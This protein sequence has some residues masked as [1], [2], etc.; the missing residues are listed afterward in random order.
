MCIYSYFSEE[1]FSSGYNYSEVQQKMQFKLAVAPIIDSDQ[2]AHPH[3]L[4][5][6]FDGR[7]MGSQGIDVSSG[8]KQR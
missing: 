3:S 2:P 1:A 6:V 5:R 8:G 4:I 7:S